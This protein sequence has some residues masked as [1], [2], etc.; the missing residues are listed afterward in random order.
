[1]SVA[2][3]A[4]VG[5]LFVKAKPFLQK[6]F[7]ALAVALVA[8]VILRNYRTI[9]RHIWRC[10]FRQSSLADFLIYRQ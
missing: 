8:G 3:F 10:L 4:L 7:R 5:L 1:M 9:R 2:A 6:L